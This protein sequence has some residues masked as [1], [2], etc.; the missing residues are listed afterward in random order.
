MVSLALTRRTDAVGQTRIGGV[1]GRIVTAL[2]EI[3]KEIRGEAGECGTRAG[4]P[5]KSMRRP[6]TNFFSI[7]QGSEALE[8]NVQRNALVLSCFTPPN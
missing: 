7:T 6:S 4:R 5:M 1:S 8:K 3:R 2:G